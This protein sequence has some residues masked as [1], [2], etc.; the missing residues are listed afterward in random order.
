MG[1]Q[2]NINRQEAKQRRRNNN[3]HGLSGV[4][5]RRKRNNEGKELL[6]NSIRKETGF[7]T[8]DALNNF[9]KDPK[10]PAARK[11]LIK[12]MHAFNLLDN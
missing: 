4:P 1:K 2:S 6:P 12:N 3:K 9:L 10:I 7:K 5:G 8:E 11:K